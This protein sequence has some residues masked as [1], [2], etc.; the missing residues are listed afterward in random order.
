MHISTQFHCKS[1]VPKGRNEDDKV[2]FL[3]NN[4]VR[5][6]IPIN[7][8]EVHYVKKDHKNKK[9]SIRFVSYKNLK[10]KKKQ[11]KTQ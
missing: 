8:K 4:R 7:F 11:N 9:K 10:N 2:I 6:T 3:V 1:L 5:A